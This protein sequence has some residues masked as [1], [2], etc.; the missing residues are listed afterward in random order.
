M[1]HPTLLDIGV[2]AYTHQAEVDELRQRLHIAHHYFDCWL[3]GFLENK[4]FNI[5]EAVSKL[6]RRETFEREQLAKSTVTDWMMEN[7]RKGIM[8]IIGNDKEGRV[9][10]YVVTARDKPVAARRAESKA[11]FDMMVSYGTRLRAESKRCQMV[12]LINQEKASLW[13]NMDMTF[14]A[15]IALHISKFYPGVVDKM[16]VCNMNRTLAAMA[17]PI[18]SRLPAIVSDRIMIITDAEMKSGKLLEYFDESVLPVALGGTNDCDRPENYAKFAVNVREHFEQLKSAVLFRGLSVKEWELASLFPHGLPENANLLTE[19]RGTD[20]LVS[21]PRLNAAE[22]S[23]WSHRPPTPNS[24]I[25]VE[26]VDLITC[27]SL[28]ANCFSAPQGWREGRPVGELLSLRHSFATNK[29]SLV[30]DYVEQFMLLE[31]FFRS[32]IVET[33]ER[34][35]LSILQREVPARR[36]LRAAEQNLW[37]GTLLFQ[38]LPLPVQLISKG[39][40]WLALMV[41]SMYFLIATIF[42]TL[43]LCCFMNTLFFSMFIAPYNV[44]PYGCALFVTGFQCVLFCS[45]GI[46]LLRRTY[47]G[48][49]IDAFRAIGPKGLFLQAVVCVAAMI[50]FFVVFCVMAAR[51]NVVIGMQYSAGSGWM[52]TLCIIVLYHFLYAFGVT[53]YRRST[54]QSDGGVATLYFFLDVDMDA[55]HNAVR[56]AP[57]M[58]VAVACV[59]ALAA[60]ACGLAYMLHGAFFFLSATVAT[61]SLVAVLAVVFVNAGH[62]HSTGSLL[63]VAG[64]H[65]CFTWLALVFTSAA[66]GWRGDWGRSSGAL[67]AIALA[68]DTVVM[69]CAFMPL[70]NRVARRWIFRAAWLWVVMQF[71]AFLILAF[72]TDY[73][74]G[75]ITLAFGL[76]LILYGL[77]A[78]YGSSN[79][80][81]V[82][83]VAVFVAVLLYCIVGGW[84]TARAR[85]DTPASRWLLPNY[86]RRE[87]AGSAF[88]TYEPNSVPLLPVCWARFS[89]HVDIVG[90]ALFAKLLDAH[91][92]NVTLTDLHVWFPNFTYVFNSTFSPQSFLQTKVF[93][94][95]SNGRATTI[96]TLGSSEHIY[97]VME[98]M[99]MWVNVMAFSLLSPVTP[100]QWFI[101]LMSTLTATEKFSPLLWKG[102][103]GQARKEL[104]RYVESVV[105]PGHDVFLVGH[106]LAGAVSAFLVSDMPEDVRGVTFSSPLNAIAWRSGSQWIPDVLPGRVLSIVTSSAWLAAHWIWGALVETIPCWSS[107]GGCHSI[108]SMAQRLWEICQQSATPPSD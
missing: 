38:R 98:S 20:S 9:A 72:I 85:Y 11:N 16:Y 52:V 87:A 4:K 84:E 65:S 49:L 63:I 100:S 102:S 14:Q 32:S 47:E 108:Q 7:M 76:H 62:S 90:M 35:W 67:L 6:G 41:M 43:F 64:L 26:S 40:L 48:Q 78:S 27:D 3:Y 101:Q 70:R 79:Y 93:E 57:T 56:E 22:D 8:Q 81:V 19:R 28:D 15:D 44:F 60:F 106:G 5:E 25:G 37:K 23:L 95:S 82:F 80:G 97:P 88:L 12:M 1:S 46:E 92:M 96:V 18:F 104:V 94:T 69:I 105:R 83:P 61:T 31:T 91:S 36:M 58:E 73:R 86:A 66:H 29:R 89:P 75:I 24:F 17:K 107:E 55:N 45:R 99:T 30:D 2:T 34:E 39:V 13:S 59:V 51:H 54:R 77:R 33:A 10:F 68:T 71:A 74:L 21:P 42:G 103:I 53:G 50:A